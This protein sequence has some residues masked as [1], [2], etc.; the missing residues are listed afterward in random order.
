MKQQSYANNSEWFAKKEQCNI[1]CHCVV[2]MQ[3]VEVNTTTVCFENWSSQQM[4]QIDQHACNEKQ[5]HPFPILSV[6][7]KG[8]NK[9]KTKVQKVVNKSLHNFESINC[10]HSC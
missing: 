2:G 9:R 3:R 10:T 4:I 6:E 5:V 7:Y 1:P 8:N